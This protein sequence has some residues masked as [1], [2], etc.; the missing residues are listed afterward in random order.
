VFTSE[1]HSL[2][3]AARTGDLNALNQL[4]QLVRPLLQQQVR[5]I[6]P[7]NFQARFDSS[8][9][10][11]STLGDAYAAFKMFEGVTLH[12]F[13]SWLN[14]IQKRNIFDLISANR[15][16]CRNVS[17]ESPGSIEEQV[18]DSREPEHFV[19]ADEELELYWSCL[20][21]LAEIDQHVI[22]LRKV[23]RL[24]YSEIAMMLQV[25]ESTARQRFFRAEARWIEAIRNATKAN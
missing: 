22:H 14:T 15:R 3:H 8:D 7:R 5:E 24:S 19:S 10:V 12:E 25:E 13:W 16:D 11:Q 23:D 4:M 21:S 6:L 1:Y 18:F 9:V 17:R 2:F 20:K